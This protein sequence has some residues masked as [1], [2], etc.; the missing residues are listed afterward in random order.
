[1]FPSLRN[2]GFLVAYSIIILVDAAG[3]AFRCNKCG[4]EF[5]SDQEKEFK[6]HVSGCTDRTH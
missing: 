1:M 3:A 5:E 4:A 6:D 2:F